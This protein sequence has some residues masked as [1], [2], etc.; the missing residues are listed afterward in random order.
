MT[1]ISPI[2][3]LSTSGTT[4]STSGT[5]VSGAKDSLG[6]NQF[7]MLMM[8]QLKAQD[9]LSPSDPTQYVSELANFTSLEQQTNIAQSTSSAATEQASSS[10]LGLLGRTVS[11]TDGNGNA[12][13]GTVSKVSFA[14]SGPTLTIGSASGITLSRITEAS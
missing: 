1:N 6:K 2:S 4:L 9:P 5:T 12:H 3:S 13:S 7:L 11:Y 8:D 10:A 14:A